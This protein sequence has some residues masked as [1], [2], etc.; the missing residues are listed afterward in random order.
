MGRPRRT[1]IRN[2]CLHC[3]TPLPVNRRADTKFC[4]PIT[5]TRNLPEWA[6]DAFASDNY[7]GKGKYDYSCKDRF[8][9][10]RKPDG[11]LYFSAL[12]GDSDFDVVD[13]VVADE[14]EFRASDSS[15]GKRR[16]AIVA[17]AVGTV[18]STYE[19]EDA[20]GILPWQIRSAIYERFSNAYE[21]PET[22]REMVARV[23]RRL[24][25]ATPPGV[26]NITGRERAAIHRL[27]PDLHERLIRAR[28][29]R[30]AWPA[31]TTELGANSWAA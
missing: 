5:G 18:Q 9:N 13:I 15:G 25:Q 21:S 11:N 14:R 30:T 12:S 24:A 23:L 7:A 16:G 10:A 2:N 19:S 29:M 31:N 8:N 3:G 4:P 20:E 22:D 6:K 26:I 1:P 17:L 28:A 27:L